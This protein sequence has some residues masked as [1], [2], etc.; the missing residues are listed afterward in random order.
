MKSYTFTLIA[1]ILLI[2]ISSCKKDEVKIIPESKC[3]IASVTFDGVDKFD[4][5]YN[6]TLVSEIYSVNNNDF[7]KFFYNNDNRLIRRELYTERGDMFL[8]AKY[9][10]DD[11]DKLISETLGANDYI[12]KY[13]SANQMISI[14][15]IIEV[16]KETK[17]LFEYTNNTL[18][19]YTELF[20]ADTTV[21]LKSE[22]LYFYSTEPNPLNKILSQFTLIFSGHPIFLYNKFINEDLLVSQTVNNIYD[23]SNDFHATYTTDYSYTVEGKNLKSVFENGLP[24]MTFEYKCD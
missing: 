3:K 1:L 12:Y 22:Y 19:K 6:G 13:N 7:K 9:N 4:L 14:N 23:F 10:Y 16:E 17:E 5:T 15:S 8:V 18:S 11:S 2:G 24:I 20:E 21:R